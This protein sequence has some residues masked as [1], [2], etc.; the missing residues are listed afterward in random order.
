[1]RKKAREENTL[2]VID[3]LY[4]PETYTCSMFPTPAV[5]QKREAALDFLKRHENSPTSFQ[6]VKRA[7]GISVTHL[8]ELQAELVKD[9]KLK[10]VSSP[11][12]RSVWIPSLDGV[13]AR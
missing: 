4:H 10:I 5:R 12:K 2:P 13:Y 7:V 9:G 1:V 11:G 8:R 6:E 3:L